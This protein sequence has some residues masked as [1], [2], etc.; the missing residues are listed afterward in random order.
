MLR[1]D[2]RAS[3][4][5]GDVDKY[6]LSALIIEMTLVLLSGV[7]LSLSLA[8]GEVDWNCGGRVTF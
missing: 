4:S 8:R 6:S 3:R 1:R 2:T 7:A 5:G